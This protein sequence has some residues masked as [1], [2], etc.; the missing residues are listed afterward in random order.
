MNTPTIIQLQ[1]E[2]EDLK[3]QDILSNIESREAQICLL[4]YTIP[5][6]YLHLMKPG[7]ESHFVMTFTQGRELMKRQMFNYNPEEKSI[8]EIIYDD[9]FVCYSLQ[10]PKD[11]YNF[12]KQFI[13]STVY[14]YYCKNIPMDINILDDCMFC[15]YVPLDR[16]NLV[17]KEH[18][19]TI[20]QLIKE[21]T[22]ISI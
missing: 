2:L 14:G 1:R 15:N 17:K 12:S 5:D 7:T 4:R 11:I 10:Q 6:K 22:N 3:L 21:Y 13:Y 20:R 16:N 18:W 9:V 8:G 19:K